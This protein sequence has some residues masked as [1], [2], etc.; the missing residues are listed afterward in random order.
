MKQL[1]RL[2]GKCSFSGYLFDCLFFSCFL[3]KI[4]FYGIKKLYVKTN[5]NKSDSDI[6]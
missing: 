6:N 4:Q 1:E 2:K 5:I 3:W